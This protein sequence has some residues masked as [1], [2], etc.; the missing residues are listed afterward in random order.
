MR[1]AGPRGVGASVS[2]AWV[3][4]PRFTGCRLQPRSVSG[5]TSPTQPDGGEGVTGGGGGGGEAAG[6]LAQGSSPA[7]SPQVPAPAQPRRPALL[8]RGPGRQVQRGGAE[9]ERAPGGGGGGRVG[10]R[11]QCLALVSSSR[12]KRRLQPGKGRGRGAGPEEAPGTPAPPGPGGG[13]LSGDLGPHR[14]RSPAPGGTQTGH[15]PKAASGLHPVLNPLPPEQTRVS[16]ETGLV[17]LGL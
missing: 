5:V 2:G 11:G 12:D 15:V 3:R 16:W 13:C 6:I 14:S 8:G 4:E 1:R 7:W 17:A 10:I 9:R